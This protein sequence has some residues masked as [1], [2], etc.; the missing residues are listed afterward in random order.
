MINKE[1]V[2]IDIFDTAIFRTTYLPTDIFKLKGDEFCRKRIDAEHRAYKEGKYTLDEIYSYLPEYN[3]Q[4]EIDLEFQ[5]TMPNVSILD[6]YKKQEKDYIFISDMYMSSETLKKLLEKNGYNDPTVFVSCELGAGKAKGELFKVVENKLGRKITKHWGDNYIADVLGVKEAGIEPVFNPAI[7]DQKLNLPV[8]K[9]SKLKKF[10]AVIEAST[11]LS[12]IEKLAYYYA[13]LLVNFT[14][15]VLSKRQEGQEIYF[16][17]RDMYMCYL[18]AKDY[19]KAQ[20]IHYLHASR[21]S[22]AGICMNSGNTELI[23]KIKSIFPNETLTDLETE[24][25]IKYLKSTGIK[26]N[27]IIVD[28]GYSGTIQKAID[29]ALDIKLKGLY[30]QVPTNHIKGIEYEMYFNRPAIQY[31]LM[32]EFPISSTED[33]IDRYLDCKPVFKPDSDIRKKYSAIIQETILNF[34]LIDLLNEFNISVYDIEQLLIHVQHYPSEYVLQIYNEKIFSNRYG[35][36]S[37]VGYD[38]EKIKK[39][40]LEECYE[41]SYCRPLFKQMLSQDKEY[42]YLLKYI[43]GNN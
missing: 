12:P 1:L 24:E 20:N 35:S 15:W 43:G 23:D 19:F 16:L 41:Q 34:D 2:S 33:F 8:L 3:M 21:K 18:I 10:I 26:N 22:M 6:M 9:N 17:S 38:K 42:S 14:K 37:I 36:E 27:D 32:C 5:N 31:C 30:M 29:I 7:H 13:P 28:I 4:D 40:L 11:S 39:G 25:T